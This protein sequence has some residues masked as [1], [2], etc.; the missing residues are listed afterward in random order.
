M[1]LMRWQARRVFEYV[2]ARI[3]ARLK[4]AEVAGSLSLSSSHF[5]R[6]F[7]R[8]FGVTVHAYVMRR[9]I[10]IAQHLMLTTSEPLSEIALRCGLSDQSHLTRW[11]RR[12]AGTTPN[13]WRRQNSS[14]HGRRSHSIAL[15]GLVSFHPREERP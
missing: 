1:T 6:E 2:E 14:P 7:K 11:H 10:E 13:A 5:C 15:P 4:V 8:T 12:V 3:E 9:R